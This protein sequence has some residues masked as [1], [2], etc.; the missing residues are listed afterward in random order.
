MSYREQL[1]WGKDN[2][3]MDLSLAH[4]WDIVASKVVSP[5]TERDISLGVDTSID[6]RHIFAV[7]KKEQNN[8]DFWRRTI[9]RGRSLCTEKAFKARF[10]ALLRAAP[11]LGYDDLEISE[12]THQMLGV[13]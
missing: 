5:R 12:V 6:I 7:Y 3:V 2:F 10:L 13:S 11:A 4:P 8:L 1:N 9:S